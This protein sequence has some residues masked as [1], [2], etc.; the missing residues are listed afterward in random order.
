MFLAV[1]RASGPVFMF[2]APRHVLGGSEGVGSCFH[3]L[4]ARTR[5]QRYRG[6]PIVFSC[7]PLPD[8]FLAVQTASG[9]VFMF[10]ASRHIF[11]GTEG[12]ASRFNIFL[13]ARTRFRRNRG[14]RVPFSCFALPDTFSTVPRASGLVFMYCAPG[15]V[16]GG[17][18][19]VDSHFH[20][21]CPG[22][23]FGETEGVSSR[24]QVLR[25]R[26]RLRRY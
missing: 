13:H 19:G 18:D 2:Y 4:R 14:R 7:F 5:F 26:T 25:V 10:F 23:V 16:F 6:R 21:L 22:L 8:K 1:P 15:L 3:V 11:G 9:T 17:T 20:V 12:V 24:F